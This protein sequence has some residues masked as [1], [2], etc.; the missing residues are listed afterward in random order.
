LACEI[1]RSIYNLIDLS[2]EGLEEVKKAVEENNI[3]KADRLLKEY[4]LNR[5]HP[6][7]FF[8]DSE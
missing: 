4:Y 2:C 8:K 5:S 6:I 1:K 7:L 3:K